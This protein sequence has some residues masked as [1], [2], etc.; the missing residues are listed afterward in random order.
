MYFGFSEREKVR[1]SQS[2]IERSDVKLRLS[3]HLRFIPMLGTIHSQRG[4][5]LFPSWEYLRCFTLI[6]NK[7]PQK[8]VKF[9]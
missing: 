9:P 3:E 8:V 1:R 2:S 7:D 5:Y 4:N 6:Y